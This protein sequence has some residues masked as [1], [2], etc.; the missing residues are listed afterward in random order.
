M[1]TRANDTATK[2]AYESKRDAYN[3]FAKMLESG[4]PPNDWAELLQEAQAVARFD[5]PEARAG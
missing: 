2:R 4:H 3:V 5:R 1:A